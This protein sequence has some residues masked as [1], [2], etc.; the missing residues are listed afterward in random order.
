VFD[1][2]IKYAIS[3][4]VGSWNEVTKDTLTAYA[5]HLADDN[6]APKTL[7]N[8]LVTLVQAQKWML[9][10][11]HLVGVEPIRVSVQSVESQ[12]AYCYTPEEVAAMVAHCLDNADLTWLAG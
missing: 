9:N 2:F 12:R 1:K 8:E 6:Y 11:K 4:S 10:E 5:T 3:I 7:R